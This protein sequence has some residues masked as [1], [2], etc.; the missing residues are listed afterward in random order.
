MVHYGIQVES[1]KV[2]PCVRSWGPSVVMSQAQAELKIVITG[3]CSGLV[4]SNVALGQSQF[5]LYREKPGRIGRSSRERDLGG[6]IPSRSYI[7]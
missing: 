7:E 2:Y 5:C 3:S 4:S 1:G 6:I